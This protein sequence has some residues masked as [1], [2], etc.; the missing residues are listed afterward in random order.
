MKKSLIVLGSL[1]VVL[2]FA[3][4]GFSG[5]SKTNKIRKIAQAVT[6]ESYQQF[7]VNDWEPLKNP[8][9]YYKS[10]ELLNNLCSEKIIMKDASH[11]VIYYFKYKH[12]SGKACFYQA[13]GVG[14]NNEDLNMVNGITQIRCGQ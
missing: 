13:I 1:M 7:S 2:T 8:E 14:D 11:L 5:T 10:G 6:A 4:S 9:A 12:V 3:V